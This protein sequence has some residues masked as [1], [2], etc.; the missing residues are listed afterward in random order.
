MCQRQGVHFVPFENAKASWNAS[1]FERESL[2]GQFVGDFLVLG[3]AGKGGFGRILLA[4]QRP[5]FR[6]RGAI[7]LLELGG[8]DAAISKRVLDKFENEAAVLAVLNHPNIVRLLHYGTHQGLPYIAMEFVPGGH[9]LQTEMNRLIVQG[10]TLEPTIFK[11]ILNQ[12]LDG[13]E[14]A[15]EL[16]IIHRDIKP[17][18]IMLHAVVGNPHHVKLLDFGIAKVIEHRRDTSVVMGTVHYMA[19]EQIEARN[20]GPWTDLYAMGCIAFE[21][22]TGHRAFPGDDPQAVLHQK[23]SPDYD[24]FAHLGPHRLPPSAVEFLRKALARDPANRY[25]TTAEFRAALT[26]VYLSSATTEV[27][28]QQLNHIVDSQEL[29]RLKAEHQQLERARLAIDSE[30]QQLDSARR[31]LEIVRKKLT[32]ERLGIPDEVESKAIGDTIAAP[33]IAPLHPLPPGERP[34]P[35]PGLQTGLTDVGQ[36]SGSDGSSDPRRR[37]RWAWLVLALLL[38]GGGAAFIAQQATIAPPAPGTSTTLSAPTTQP[39]PVAN[40]DAPSGEASPS[41]RSGRIQGPVR[42]HGFAGH[43]DL[44]S[45]NA[46]AGGGGCRRLGPG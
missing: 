15:H 35:V 33:S 16:N 19:P 4:L 43:R 24:P 3:R 39:P 9:T 8:H 42:R 10:S 41:P 46:R 31:D 34:K 28:A 36:R 2:V 26:T 27:F 21:F 25:R 6:L 40:L 14:A 11:H 23:L 12:V 29:T 32:S 5:L 30:R 20:L 45:P 13:L 22:I 7:K 1:S 44:P 38:A 17:E 18:N 37:K